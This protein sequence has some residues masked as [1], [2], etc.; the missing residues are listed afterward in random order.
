MSQLDYEDEINE[1]IVSEER[2]Y[3]PTIC[4]DIATDMLRR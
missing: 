2:N 3:T 1:F 4:N